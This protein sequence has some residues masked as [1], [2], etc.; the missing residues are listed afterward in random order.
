MKAAQG[1]TK[2]KLITTRKETGVGGLEWRRSESTEV[3]L[4]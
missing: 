2:D 4:G 1:T 3:Q